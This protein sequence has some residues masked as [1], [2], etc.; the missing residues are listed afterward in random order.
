[1]K[2][3]TRLGK[4]GLKISD[5]LKPKHGLKGPIADWGGIK[6]AEL[7][8]GQ[9]YGAEPNWKAFLANGTDIPIPTLNNQGA[10]ALLFVP[11][12]DRYLIYMFGYGH[13]T[14]VE[15]KTEWDFGVKVVIN[16]INA[17][18]I[19]SLDSKTVGRKAKIKRVQ[20]GGAGTIAEFDLD[21][22]QDLVSQISG[23][24]IDADFAKGLT[25]S[26]S[27]M[28]TVDM[29]SSS[30]AKK[31][32]QIL[33][34]YGLVNYKTNFEWIDFVAPI[35]ERK[36]I[37]LLDVELFKKVDW[38]VTNNDAE[39]LV[40]SYPEII[41]DFVIDHICYRGFDSTKESD[42]PD[43]ASFLEEYLGKGYASLKHALDKIRLEVYDDGD[44]VKRNYTLYRSLTA[45][46]EYD[47]SYYI[48]SNGLWFKL[49]KS[50]YDTV[51][52]FF[53][54]LI[55]STSEYDGSRTTF[56]GTE[57]DYFSAGAELGYE[58]MDRV[59]YVRGRDK[60]E[61]ADL[62]STS[63]EIVHVKVGDS[64]SKLS[65]LFNQ[66]LVS[67]RLMLNDVGFR[68]DFK[69]AIKDRAIISVFDTKKF[70]ANEYTVVFRIIR[71]GKK[72]H[73]PFF[74]KITLYDTYQKI[75]AMGYK[76][77]LEWLRYGI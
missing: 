66:G 53:D 47:S 75:T 45:E 20:L 60:I 55:S 7:Y 2:L 72:F 30:I 48:F 70:Y 64:S 29:S 34:R 24:S 57:P 15:G 59:N 18:A 33:K 46:L 51:T 65:H 49:E 54:K 22:M 13:S 50:Y 38:A 3:T 17:N 5:L 31:T 37:D 36:L 19:R 35:K 32:V 8:Y 68:K 61:F 58:L 39:G 52:K 21:I 4:V 73:L 11:T 42:I 71:S 14:L 63:R 6:G 16:T 23:I 10:A 77:R 9:S 44:H 62:I 56:C 40:I 26:E 27:L 12:S 28:M 69:A 1:M 76:F 74:S 67:A 41:D 43:M 25:G